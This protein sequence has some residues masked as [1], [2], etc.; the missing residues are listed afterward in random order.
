MYNGYVAAAAAA[1]QAA[2]QYCWCQ[3]LWRCGAQRWSMEDEYL[4][5]SV[6][7]DWVKGWLKDDGSGI[8]KQC[9]PSAV[10]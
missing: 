1:A 4:K 10:Q 2:L 9:Q 8:S 5:R 6:N 3:A 7:Q